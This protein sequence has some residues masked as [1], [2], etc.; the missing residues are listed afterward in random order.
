MTCMSE[1]KELV[2]PLQQPC[3]SS[4]HFTVKLDCFHGIM[5]ACGPR[6]FMA[7]TLTECE[8]AVATLQAMVDHMLQS[9]DAQLRAK[10]DRVA[11]NSKAQQAVSEPLLPA[12]AADGAGP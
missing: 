10:R 1:V 4:P 2:R 9:L 6:R 3:L 8:R 7:G 11:A 12:A 5:L